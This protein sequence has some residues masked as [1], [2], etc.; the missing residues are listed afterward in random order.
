MNLPE[1]VMTTRDGKT[2]LWINEW[3]VWD[4]PNEQVT[5]DVLDAILHAYELGRIHAR[6]EMAHAIQVIETDYSSA[7]G[8]KD[9]RDKV[10]GKKVK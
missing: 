4:L 8:W 10:K 1:L 6:D 3:N 9:G 7:I 5:S 2:A